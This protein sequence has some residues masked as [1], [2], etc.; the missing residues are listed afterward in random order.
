MSS[1][2]CCVEISAVCQRLLFHVDCMREKRH[3]VMTVTT[4]GPIRD[5]HASGC[6]LTPCSNRET[7]IN[8]IYT[9]DRIV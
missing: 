6:P 1:S 4:R 5:D 7:F 9:V 8:R 2:S 3:I